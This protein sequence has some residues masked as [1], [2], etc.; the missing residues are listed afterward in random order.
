MG[1]LPLGAHPITAPP[2]AGQDVVFPRHR[3]SGP[4]HRAEDG[5]FGAAEAL[6]GG[7]GGA[8]RAVVF[9]QQPAVAVGGGLHLGHIA[10]GAALAGEGLKARLRIG[11]AGQRRVIGGAG[12][13]LARGDQPVERLFAQKIADMADPG[14]GQLGMGIGK[15]GLAAIGQV[16]DL[17]RA[18]ELFFR[19]FRSL[20]E[21]YG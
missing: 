9:D 5:E 16:P 17:G 7:G 11:R 10:F 13:G 8:D 18:A 21:Q 14:D 15:P 2:S 6:A 19:D 12:F 20:Q 1:A 3:A 4:Q